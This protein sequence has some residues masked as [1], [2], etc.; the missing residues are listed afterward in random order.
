VH[1]IREIEA[2]WLREEMNRAGHSNQALYLELTRE[3]WSGTVNNISNWRNGLSPIPDEVV[4]ML[5]RAFDRD[6][7]GDGMAD[8]VEF[9]A[10]R[11]PWMRP[12]LQ[13]PPQPRRS[14]TMS[15][16]GTRTEPVYYGRRGT[17]QGMRFVLYQD[18]RG[19]YI[20]GE[21]RFEKDKQVF[22]RKDE[23]TRALKASPELR[24]RMVP[25]NV[26]GAAPS[27]IHQRSLV[28]E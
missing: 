17:F 21:T 23:L 9:L 11:Y 20:A 12:Y 15:G 3:G 2:A 1:E 22:A 16:R 28:W 19:R 27:L 10:R 13:S 25:E 4:P 26:P 8:V 18:S 14:E 5:V 24:V 6:P 7:E